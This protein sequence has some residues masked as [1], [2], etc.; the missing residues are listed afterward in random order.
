MTVHEGSEDSARA[1]AARTK[2][3]ARNAGYRSTT[4]S[5]AIRRAQREAAAF[6]G[7]EDEAIRNGDLDPRVLEIARLEC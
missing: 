5:A 1:D 6:A 7:Y 2:D 4:R 3:R